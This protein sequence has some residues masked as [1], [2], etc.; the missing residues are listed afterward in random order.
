MLNDHYLNLKQVLLDK[1]KGNGGWVNCHSHIDRSF[2][3]DKRLYRLANA[4]RHEKWLLNADLRKSSTVSQVY[5]RMAR[6][7]EL[8][9]AQ[10]VQAVGS[11]IDID[12]HMKD[13][14]IQ[15]AQKVRDKYKSQITIKFINHS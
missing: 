14:A 1:I 6:S 8:M 10:N 12:P 7:L 9:I 4:L 3:I 5:D 11:F 13:K 2:T 15:A